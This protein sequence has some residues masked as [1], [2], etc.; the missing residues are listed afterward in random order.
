ML[1]PGNAGANDAEDTSSCWTGGRRLAC[2]Y[3]VGHEPGDDPS[4]VRRHILVRADSA[5]ASHFFVSGLVEANIEYSI[6]HQVSAKVRE[7]LL[8]FQE[9]DWVQLSKP[10]APSAK[11][12][13]AELT[14]LMDLR[15]GRGGTAH[16]APGTAAPGAQLSCST[17]PRD[18]DYV[19]H[20]QRADNDVTSPS[21]SWRHRGTTREDAIRNWKDCGLPT[22]VRQ[23]H[24]NLAWVPQASS[25]VAARVGADDLFGR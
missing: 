2:D 16:H 23:L 17:S 7:A 25:P 11:R 3:Q 9:E 20:H 10:T 13:L 21:S 8:L 6:G 19:L 4:L 15:R 18:T 5:G 14:P 12:F 1:R 22:A 24:Q